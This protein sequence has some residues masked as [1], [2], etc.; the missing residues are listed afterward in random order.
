MSVV[1]CVKSTVP[2]AHKNTHNQLFGSEKRE[3]LLGLGIQ[4]SNKILFGPSIG[5]EVK[6]GR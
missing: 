2:F 6:C 3:N 5:A 1:L 4:A